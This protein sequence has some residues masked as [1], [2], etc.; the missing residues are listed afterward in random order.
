M[1]FTVPVDSG[2]LRPGPLDYLCDVL[3]PVPGPKAVLVGGRADPLGSAAGLSRLLQLVPGTGVLRS[4]L[5]AF[6]CLVQGAGFAAFGIDGSMRRAAP[7]ATARKASGGGPSSPMVLFPELMAFSLGLTLAKR[8]DGEAP[9][10]SC[11]Q[12]EGECLDR[13]SSMAQQSAAAGHNACVLMG[14]A[15]ELLAVDA[16]DRV[17]W[18]QR[19][20]RQALD[21]YPMWNARI[22]QIQG[23][24]ASPEL[25]AWAERPARRVAVQQ[26]L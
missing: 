13:F 25:R 11:E 15:R 6:G 8:F 1:V 14:W 24:T 3:R 17:D 18:W 23:F 22:G 19:R 2:W 5:G 26:M 21:G 10:C 4:G 9:A 12:C 16:V 20:C 7:P